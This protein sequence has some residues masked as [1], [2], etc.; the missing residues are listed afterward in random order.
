MAWM[1]Q[2][3]SIAG[4]ANSTDPQAQMQGFSALQ[5][6][7]PASQLTQPPPQNQGLNLGVNTNLGFANNSNPFA[8]FFSQLTKL[9]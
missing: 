2:A 4:A 6:Q 8:N 9:Q 1:A 3:A 5:S 7:R